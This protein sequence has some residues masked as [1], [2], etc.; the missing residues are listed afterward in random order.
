MYPIVPSTVKYREK[1]VTGDFKSVLALIALQY[2]SVAL[3][4]KYE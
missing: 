2:I 1:R 4:E 3:K